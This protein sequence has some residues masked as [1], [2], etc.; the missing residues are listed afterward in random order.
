MG[1]SRKGFTLIELLV[2]MAIIGVLA[3]IVLPVFA[4]ARE[5][6]RRAVC[7]NNVKNVAL[8]I[9]MY[10][11][12]N[13]DTLP[14]YE[15][16][17][18]VYEWWA[19]HAPW[20]EEGCVESATYANPYLRWPVILDEYVKNREVWRCPSASVEGAAGNI[21]PTPDWFRAVVAYGPGIMSEQAMSH[22]LCPLVGWWPR[23]W[24]GAVTDS[25]RQ[26]NAFD[27]PRSFRISIGCNGD[28]LSPEFFAPHANYGLRVVQ[29]GDPAS[30]VICGDAG[31]RACVDF[32]NLGLAA[33]PEICR[34]TC[35]QPCGAGGLDPTAPADGSL[36]ADP[37][38]RKRY[39][40]HFGG[41]NLGFLDGHVAWWNSESLIAEFAARSRAGE[42]YPLGLHVTGPTSFEGTGVLRA[43][44]DGRQ[45]EPGWPTIF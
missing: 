43:H 18:D 3:G 36:L 44:T 28:S 24:G 33:Y 26:G 40:R 17:R 21:S 6:G 27:D 15:S 39:A 4:R 12:D 23:G 37:D 2:V 1:G 8:A 35:S 38:K 16:R 45:C 20:W 22:G 25:F 5:S 41:V 29:V 31:H 32:C 19:A 42:P 7:L 10:L 11:A 34:L 14:P 9:Q 13:N 30:F